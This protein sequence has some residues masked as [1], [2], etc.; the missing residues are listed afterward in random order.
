ML[1]KILIPT[2]LT[3][4]LFANTNL[5]TQIKNNAYLDKNQ[6]VSI[7]KKFPNGNIV[8]NQYKKGF[9]K[10]YIQP[11]K[12]FYVVL[13]S[14]N[15]QRAQAFLTKDK[16]YLI[17]GQVINLKSKKPVTGHMPINKNVLKKG[18][19][20]T[21]GKGNK[22][23]YLVTDPECPF[24]K[25]MYRNK[26][27]MTK[28]KEHYRVNVILY[29]LSFHPHSAKMSLYVLAGKTDKER[30]KRLDE[31]MNNPNV[32]KNFNPDKKTKE[33]LL[34]ELNNSKKAA[35]ELGFTGTPQMFDAKTYNQ[36]GLDEIK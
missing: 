9:L 2:T 19:V 12:E 5:S 31:V 8:V 29:P 1:K 10:A 3:L 20:F 35:K 33:K 18:V 6:T 28:L 21:F 27:I 23:I 16:K 14:Q 34:K 17:I 26:G 15:G 4:S 25:A 11:K 24:C 30:K 36:I 13:L 32:I 7:L 22:E